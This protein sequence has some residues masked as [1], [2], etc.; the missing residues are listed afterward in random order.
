MRRPGPLLAVV[1]MVA[2]LGAGVLAGCDEDGSSEVRRLGPTPAPGDPSRS[3]PPTAASLSRPPPSPTL[4]PAEMY[5][6]L[7]TD[8]Q[9]ARS[10]FFGTISSG[11][12]LTLARQRATA[13]EYLAALR[14]FAAGVRAHQWPAAAR[15]AVA[16]LLAAN[17]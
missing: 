3:G 13:A 4:G 15:A 1:A 16:E 10:R 8:W 7:V 14:R 6:A 11:R 17:A 5:Q 2:G 12:P 9:R